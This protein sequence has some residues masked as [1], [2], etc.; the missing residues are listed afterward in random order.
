M[1]LYI[2]APG[3]GEKGQGVGQERGKGCA[4]VA[5][6]RGLDLAQKFV[7]A[8]TRK[9]FMLNEEFSVSHHC[10]VILQRVRAS[11]QRK[12]A[13][14]SPHNGRASAT[15]SR[16]ACLRPAPCARFVLSKKS[17]SLYV[18]GSKIVNRSFDPARVRDGEEAHIK[19]PQRGDKEYHLHIIGGPMCGL[20]SCAARPRAI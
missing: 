12:S 11:S 17:R 20:C 16:C 15:I 3:T 1:R 5:G 2:T 8:I 13:P 9:E 18:F 19:A 10:R 7:E 4:A 6:A 14:F